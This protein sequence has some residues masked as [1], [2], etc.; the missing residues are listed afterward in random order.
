MMPRY[1]AQ[2]KQNGLFRLHITLAESTSGQIRA[3]RDGYAGITYDAPTQGLIA[4]IATLGSELH[5]TMHGPGPC[6]Q[7]FVADFD[8]GKYKPAEIVQKL[9]C[10]SVVRRATLIPQ[11]SPPVLP[12]S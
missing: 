3:V 5:P 10:H 11:P 1:A 2:W 9:M 12:V 7:E 4:E 8:N 6:A